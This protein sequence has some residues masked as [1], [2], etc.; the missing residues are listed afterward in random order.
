MPKFCVFVREPVILALNVG[1]AESETA[2]TD[3][4]TELRVVFEAYTIDGT[5][6]EVA[7]NEDILVIENTIEGDTVFV[8]IDRLGVTE[9]LAEK[10]KTPE[11]DATPETV[12]ERLAIL[13]RVLVV[14]S[15]SDSV[16]SD[17]T[18]IREVGDTEAVLSVEGD[19]PEVR[20]VVSVAIVKDDTEG[21]DET[22][23]VALLE[24]TSE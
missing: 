4:D 1:D 12:V 14:E 2:P 6:E 18:V 17:D 16:C 13:D 15:V 8:K 20:L 23:C 3:A 11:V 5:D 10:D 24:D 22:D 9:E 21:D 19:G 7:E